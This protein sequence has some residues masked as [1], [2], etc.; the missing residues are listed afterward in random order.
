MHKKN[1]IPTLLGVIILVLG[2]VAGVFLIRNTSIF[3]IGADASA[4]A[5]NIRVSNISDSNATIT[6][7]TDKPT[8]GFI[9]WGTSQGSLTKTENEN[10]SGQKYYNHSINLSGLSPSTK[11][12]YKINSEGSTF[13][14]GGIPWQFTTGSTLSSSKDSMLVSGTVINASGVPEKRALIYADLGGYLLSTLTSDTGNFV[15]QIASARTAD[16]SNYITLD[17]AQTLIQIS[18]QAPPDGIAS[19]QVF[20]QSGNPVPPIIIGQTYDFRSEPANNLGPNPGANL[21]LPQDVTKQSKIDVSVPATTPKPTSVILESLSEGEVV[22]TDKPQFFGKGPGGTTLTITVHSD[23]TLTGNVQ[24][25]QTGS[26]S[27]A[28]P[29]NLAPGTHTVTISWVDVTGITRF[30]TRDFVVSASDNPAFTASGSGATPTPTPTSTAIASASPTAAPI[31]T[32]TPVPT[33]TPSPTPAETTMPVPVTGD[34]TPTLLL[35]IMGLVVM[36]FSFVVW[37]VAEN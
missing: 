14:N 19:A 28:V 34:L 16:L 5:K 7:T 37:K 36:T 2:T 8:A 30:L 29:A 21:N 24:I 18:V 1:T 17:P 15:F 9:V 32:A 6:W 12:F 31:I 23:Q 11:Y 4:A 33:K 13:D 35:F 26:W 25:P 10:T 22:T 20:P 27:Y 3:K